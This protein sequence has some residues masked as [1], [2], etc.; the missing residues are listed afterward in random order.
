[1]L[2]LDMIQFKQLA[3]R[4]LSKLMH[5]QFGHQVIA[6]AQRD[7]SH[8]RPDGHQPRGIELRNL[9]HRVDFRLV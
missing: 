8:S 3:R 9:G 4:K 2:D 1:M 7:V 5:T 6:A